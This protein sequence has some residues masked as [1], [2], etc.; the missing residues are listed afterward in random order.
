MGS[1]C[2]APPRVIRSFWVSFQ[3]PSIYAPDMKSRCDVSSKPSNLFHCCHWPAQFCWQH[4]GLG[5]SFLLLPDLSSFSIY[6]ADLGRRFNLLIKI[7]CIICFLNLFIPLS[8]NTRPVGVPE[9]PSI[10]SIRRPSFNL[11]PFFQI[12][13]SA[14][15]IL[16]RVF[17]NVLS[18]VCRFYGDIF[19]IGAKSF[20]SFLNDL[21]EP[22]PI[23]H[24][25]QWWVMVSSSIMLL[26]SVVSKT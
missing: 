14:L 16:K 9:I 11:P 19:W 20:G 2:D 26:T 4:P 22:S 24:V 23:V 7:P 17:A 21:E 1:T 3:N 8:F 5:R 13:M 25:L 6:D 10:S 12:Y 18:C 15:W